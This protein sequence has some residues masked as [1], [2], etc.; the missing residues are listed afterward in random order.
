MG[1]FDIFRKKKPPVL[2]IQESKETAPV[3]NK[4]PEI[5][6]PTARYVAKE[7]PP[8]KTDIDIPLPKIH[9]DIKGL[10]W[11]GDGK[12]K[13]YTPENMYGFTRQYSGIRITISYGDEPSVI[14]TKQPVSVPADEMLV[15]RSPYYPT[16]S[17]LTPEQKWVYLM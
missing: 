4:K 10:V 11:I 14:Y 7:L 16:Y 1:I 8:P 17:G 3:K 5:P 15:P 2:P 9:D 13:N 12:Y 6:A